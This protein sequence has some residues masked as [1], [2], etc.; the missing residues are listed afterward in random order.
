MTYGQALAE[1]RATLASRD[2]A[3]AAFDARVL[4]AA[5]AQIDMAALIARSG[6]ALP[7]VARA[8]YDAYLKRRVDGE[9]VARIL[10]EAEFWG[11]RFKLNAA[12]LV[13]RA[14]T[15]TL[16]EAVL[17]EARRRFR[18]GLTICDLGTG[19]GAIV[20]ALLSALPQARAVA[21]DIAEEAL[22]AA[23]AN[24]K[25][26]GVAERISFVNVDFRTGPEGPF[27]IVVSNPPYVASGAIAGLQREVREHDPRRALDGGADG[28]DAYRAILL[29]IGNLVAEGGLVALEV[30][31]G[32]SEAVAALCRKGGL[33]EVA[34][35]AD[36]AGRARVVTAMRSLPGVNLKAA[37]KALGKVE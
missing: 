26:H 25:M 17:E 8:K 10:G 16:V 13:P 9:P 28:L 6:E 14:D 12:T 21:T 20:V 4:L 32:Q 1:G 15:E 27:D 3:G 19:S 7:A 37:K 36:L 34:V 24:A 23:R 33:S 29:R 5:A 11:L 35:R 30:G 22:R 2:V 18:S 31:E